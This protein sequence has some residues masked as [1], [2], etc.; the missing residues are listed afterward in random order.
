M[1]GLIRLILCGI[2][3]VIIFLL[4][5]K[6]IEPAK[7]KKA[8]AILF[9]GIFF[10]GSTLLA[11]V[12]FENLF[13]T[14][15]TPEA[16]Y[17]YFTPGKS[18]EAFLIEGK[19]STFVLKTKNGTNSSLIVP[20]TEN[21]WKV[22]I[23]TYRK[24]VFNQPFKDFTVTVFQYK[25]TSDYYIKVVD[26]NAFVQTLTDSDGTVFTKKQPSVST[27]NLS[28]VYYAY[29]SDFDATTY[30]LIVNGETVALSSVQKTEP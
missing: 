19:E 8:A 4:L 22:P 6:R 27:F 12:P 14:F 2:V 21:G 28:S 18:G 1:F 23:G 13:V 20:K 30:T 7:V 16:A 3:F 5:R 10:L 26:V 25:D 29:I 15:D 17:D 11:F 9:I 24:S